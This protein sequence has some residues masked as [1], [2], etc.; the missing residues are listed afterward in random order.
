MR[1]GY[2]MHLCKSCYNCNSRYCYLGKRW[3][4]FIA[5]KLWFDKELRQANP[6]TRRL[7]QKIKKEKLKSD[8]Y[9]RLWQVTMGLV[10]DKTDRIYELEKRDVNLG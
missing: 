6:V 3:T 10:I 7:L 2:S 5:C 1:F 8:E 9:K 4:F